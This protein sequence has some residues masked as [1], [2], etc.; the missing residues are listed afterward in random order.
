MKILKMPISPNP[1]EYPFIDLKKLLILDIETTGLSSKYNWIYLIG[2]AYYDTESK[3]W[4]IEQ[5][6]AENSSEEKDIL[7]ALLPYVNARS[8]VVTYNGDAF[9]IPFIKARMDKNRISMPSIES[10]DLFKLLKNNSIFFNLPN[11]KLRTVEESLGIFRKDQYTGKECIDFY[12]EFTETGSSY[13]REI[14]LRH[15]HDDL[16]SMPGLLSLIRIIHDSKKVSILDNDHI[17]DLHIVELGITGEMLTING[18]YTSD[19]N[20]PIRFYAQGWSID[21]RDDNTFNIS[22]ELIYATNENELEV[23]LIDISNLEFTEECFSNMDMSIPSGYVIVSAGKNLNIGNIK[24]LIRE[25][26]LSIL[27]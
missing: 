12:K 5:L 7:L 17:I 18:S 10:L 9:D 22:Y 27:V 23:A 26:L 3:E 1:G 13:L 20:M 2:L 15:N 16:C 8:L 6:F 24:T 4:F 19:Y 25:H 14:I 11:L 21:L